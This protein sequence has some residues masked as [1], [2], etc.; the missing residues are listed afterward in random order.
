MIKGWKQPKIYGLIYGIAL[1]GFTVYV[2]LDTFVIARSYQKVH[3]KDYSEYFTEDKLEKT[4]SNITDS[5]DA[6]KIGEYSSDSVQITLSQYRKYDT[7]IYVA[8]VVVAS[9]KYLKT[10]LANQTFGRNVTDKT[11]SIASENNAVFAING[12]YYGAR[13][14]GYVIRNH[15]LY[16]EN[17]SDAE[18]EDLV[19]NTDGSFSIVKEGDVTA[20]ELLDQ[21]AWQVFSFGPGLINDGNITVS[22]N[23]E[24]ALARASNPRTSIGQVDG[25]HYIFVVSDGRTNV[26]EGLSLFQ[27]AEFMK[28]LG[29]KTAYNL[30]GGGSSSMYFQGKV[31]NQPTSTGRSIKER[32]VSDIVY[33]GE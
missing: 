6:K 33:L 11:S 1:V 20:Q 32:S 13:N 10:A 28:S 5:Q 26:S 29:V 17:L 27:M 9:A 8:D 3:D 7:D 15:E 30:D 12:D 18:Q 16:R 22:S 4:E 2:L 21:G 14:H 23:T 19:I 25:L 24:V 31:I